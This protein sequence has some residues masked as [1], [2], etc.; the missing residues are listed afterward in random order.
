MEC[1]FLVLWEWDSN[2]CQYAQFA[3]KGEYSLL[4]DKNVKKI[5]H[6]LV[7]SMTLE[8]S[9]KEYWPLISLRLLMKWQL[10]AVL[11]MTTIV[12]LKWL[13][14]QYPPDTATVKSLFLIVGTCRV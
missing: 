11:Q 4:A 13:S 5:E 3:D 14:N 7:L 9:V 1:T 10:V 8:I 12:V 2:S 6:Q